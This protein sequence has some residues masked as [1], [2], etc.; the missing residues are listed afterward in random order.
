MP[1]D[2][3]PPLRPTLHV[4][5]LT[6]FGE[7]C[8]IATY[9]EALAAGLE[10]HGVEV[11]VVAPRLRPDDAPRGEQPVRV[12]RR[13]RAGVWEARQTFRQILRQQAN[14]VHVQVSMGLTSPSFLF[15]L[16]RLCARQGLPLVATLH[17]AGGGSVMRRFKFARTL[18]G[19]GNAAIIVHEAD[20]SVAN[21]PGG[22]QVIPHGIAE[23]PRR[24]RSDA[25]TELGVSPSDLV[26]AHFGFIHPDKGIE[27]VLRAVARLRKERFPNLKYRVCGGTFATTSSRSHLLHLQSIVRTLGLDGA[28]SLTGEF[29]AE[30]RVTLEMQAADL[31]LLNYQTG[32]R[33]GASGAAHR[34]LATGCSLAVTPAPIFDNL[35]EAAHTITGPLESELETL[36]AKPELRAEI[37]ARAEA[38]CAARSW[39]RVA[40]TH[41]Q[42]YRSLVATAPTA[43]H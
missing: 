33:Q 11:S 19:L 2:A 43:R 23:I 1:H 38:F 37:A 13:D 39:L 40:D 17:E 36:L 18:W 21:V 41:A 12:W 22:V 6:T 16:S 3:R 30:D 10:E 29:A 32:N 4:S 35:R 34:A 15:A 8:G 24:S 5:M 9:S 7:K 27:A 26:V 20:P 31:V 28:V 25:R 14:V 42:L